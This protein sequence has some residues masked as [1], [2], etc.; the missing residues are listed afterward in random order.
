MLPRMSRIARLAV[1]VVAGVGTLLVAPTAAHAAS[2]IPNHPICDDYKSYKVSSRKADQLIQTIPTVQL[3][4]KGTTTATLST[5][6]AISGSVSLSV[7]ASITVEASI[8]VAGAKGTIGASATVTLSGTWTTSASVTVTS[9][10]WGYIYGGI[11]RGVT[12]GTYEHIDT[13]C[14]VTKGTVTAYTPYRFGYI[15]DGN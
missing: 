6:V 1:L 11:F 15:A 13:Y 5:S 14:G 2:A 12:V 7:N 9:H 4:N 10:H 8:I 3:Y